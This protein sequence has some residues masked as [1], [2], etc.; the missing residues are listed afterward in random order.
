MIDELK[1]K[2]KSYIKEMSDKLEEFYKEKKRE[3]EEYLCSTWA[4]EDLKH[5]KEKLWQVY[6]ELK[7]KIKK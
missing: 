2:W 3:W 7:A 4:K 5:F 6:E 1:W